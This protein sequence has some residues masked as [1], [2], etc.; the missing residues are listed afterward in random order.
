MITL[1]ITEN[2]YMEIVLTI[3]ITTVASSGFWAFLQWVLQNKKDKKSVEKS[4]L[5]AL[6]HDRLYFELGNLLS[7]ETIKRTDYENVTYLYTPYKKLGG[8]G[9]CEKMYM[10]LQKKE[11]SA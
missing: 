4:A 6:L 2:K 5:L 7:E 9:T 8:N 11:I 3:I 10:D 1:V